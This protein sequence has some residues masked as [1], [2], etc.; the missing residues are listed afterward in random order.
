MFPLILV[1]YAL[2]VAIHYIKIAFDSGNAAYSSWEEHQQTS[3]LNNLIR[4]EHQ[5]TSIIESLVQDG[6]HQTLLLEGL[7]TSLGLIM[8]GTILLSGLSVFSLIKI[9][10]ISK[11]IRQ[12]RGDVK[13]LSSQVDRG[14]W[15]LKNFIQERTDSVIDYQ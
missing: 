8:S 7:Q 10:Q 3:I 9:N 11:N 1:G 2:R 12:L 13:H 6:H 14:F 15:D 5:Q 4:E